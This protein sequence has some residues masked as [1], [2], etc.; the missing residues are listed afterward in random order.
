ML[1]QQQLPFLAHRHSGSSSF[2]G[3]GHLLGGSIRG[4]ARIS[5]R[6]APQS[7]LRGT[8]SPGSTSMCVALARAPSRTSAGH[9][10]S[11]QHRGP[12]TCC[13]RSRGLGWLGSA[14]STCVRW[15]DPHP[16]S[17]GTSPCKWVLREDTFKAPGEGPGRPCRHEGP[18]C[19]EGLPRVRLACRTAGGD[20]RCRS[21]TPGPATASSDPI[22]QRRAKS[23]W[24]R[25]WALRISGPGGSGCT[26]PTVR[27]DVQVGVG[28][29]GLSLVHAAAAG[30][31]ARVTPPPS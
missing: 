13:G 15:R 6:P 2:P 3:S 19:L 24:V 25:E 12:S 31:S 8:T 18:A 5:P 7:R 1:R 30:T 20:L 26:E 21:Q 10:R 22:L 11:C 9:R 4:R 27:L 17:L 29:A 28:V 16:G 14:S 23:R